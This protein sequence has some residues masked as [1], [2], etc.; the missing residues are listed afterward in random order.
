MSGMGAE[1]MLYGTLT[2]T[3]LPGLEADLEMFR[4]VYD[5]DIQQIDIVWDSWG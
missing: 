1:D 2:V 3:T 4:A 5:V